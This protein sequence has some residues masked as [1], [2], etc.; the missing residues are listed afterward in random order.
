[1]R[2]LL[3]GG[4]GAVI[5][6]RREGSVAPLPFENFLDTRTGKMRIRKVDVA[7]DRY[8]VALKYMIRLEKD[9]LKNQKTVKAL[10][11]VG[12]FSKQALRER[13]GS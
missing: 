10:C 8:R 2:H 12:N 4:S 3:D 6:I 1:M 13:F 5:S 9:D 11:R 7:S